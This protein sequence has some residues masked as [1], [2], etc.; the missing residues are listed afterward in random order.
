M[1]EHKFSI[2]YRG[3]PLPW[4]LAPNLDTVEDTAPKA[5]VA[6]TQVFCYEGT[7][8]VNAPTQWYVQDGQVLFRGWDGTLKL[9]MATIEEL[10]NDDE[11]D[12]L[13]RIYI[14]P[15]RF[16]VGGRL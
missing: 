6:N 3:V 4:A 9:A 14:D 11:F 8:G 7:G 2:T 12:E 16:V 5:P 1:T 13:D 15:S 10:E